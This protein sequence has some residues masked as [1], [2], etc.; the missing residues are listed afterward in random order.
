MSENR[1]L[2]RLYLV[3]IKKPD[4]ESGRAA[5]T[6]HS[7]KNAI[8][9]AVTDRVRLPSGNYLIHGNDGMTSALHSQ[10]C[11]TGIYD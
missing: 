3:L 4:W 7:R 5:P 10:G 9:P 11:T 2:G 1:G 6:Q 8:F